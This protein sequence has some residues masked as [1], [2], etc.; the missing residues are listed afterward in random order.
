M[1][2]STSGTTSLVGISHPLLQAAR[3]KRP[4]QPS[5]VPSEPDSLF[6]GS[7]P[8][9][10]LTFTEPPTREPSPKRSR[11]GPNVS[12]TP[13][14][15]KSAMALPGGATLSPKRIPRTVSFDDSASV[16]SDLSS[17][18]GAEAGISDEDDDD[19]DDELE[20]WAKEFEGSMQSA[21][22]GG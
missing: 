21:G 1:Q 2:P 14:P 6:D 12:R 9:T 16:R 11:L 5:A 13:S 17:Q 18:D 15:I 19:D 7:T 4:R 22:N 10:P 20:D 8:A 3:K